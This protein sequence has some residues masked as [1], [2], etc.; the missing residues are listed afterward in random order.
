VNRETSNESDQSVVANVLL[1]A[2]SIQYLSFTS[3]IITVHLLELIAQ[4]IN[5]KYLL[6]TSV[7]V[8]NPIC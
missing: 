2:L 8:I 1:A 5:S 7:Q 4:A 6:K 3:R